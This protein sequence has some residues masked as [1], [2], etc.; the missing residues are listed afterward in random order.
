[1]GSG[2]SRFRALILSALKSVQREKAL[3]SAPYQLSASSGSSQSERKAWGVDPVG[4][5]KSAGSGSSRF[6]SERERAKP[7]DTHH[8]LL[9]LLFISLLHTANTK[10]TPP[11]MHVWLWERVVCLFVCRSEA[12]I[13]DQAIWIKIAQ[14][15]STSTTGLLSVFSLPFVFHIVIS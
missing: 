14:L 4:S 11:Q 7:G 15:G 2:S 5:E 1:V 12:E 13:G 8:T 10:Q 3:A 9:M 6:G